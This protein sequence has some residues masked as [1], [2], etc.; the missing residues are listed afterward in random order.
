MMGVNRGFS[1][2]KTDEVSINA[3]NDS[4]LVGHISSIDRCW[5][6]CFFP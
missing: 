5:G 3:G 1:V 2:D 4:W 6:I